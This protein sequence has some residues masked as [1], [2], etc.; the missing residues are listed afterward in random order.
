MGR[1]RFTV[2]VRAAP[3]RVFDLWLDLGRAQ[4]W[5]EGLTRITDITGPPDQAGT[6]YVAWFGRMRSPTEIREVT[7]PS[8]IRTKFGN[9]LLRGETRVTF[10]PENGG[11]RLTQEFV[12]E[13]IIPAIA[14]RIFATGSY[15]G[16]FRGELNMFVKIAEADPG[17]IASDA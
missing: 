11:T 10:Q 12:T 4:E 14:A 8:F 5:I 6:R 17:Q 2:H 13:G 7:R 15:K 1:Y 9:S 16:S 3:E